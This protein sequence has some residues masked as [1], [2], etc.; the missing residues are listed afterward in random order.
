[1]Q[2]WWCKMI[3]GATLVVS[4]PW[5]YAGTMFNPENKHLTLRVQLRQILLE[6]K[7]YLPRWYGPNTS[8][9]NRYTRSIT[10]L[11]INILRALSN[12]R[13]MADNQLSSGIEAP[14]SYIISSLILSQSRRYMWN[15]VPRSTWLGIISRRHCRYLNF[16]VFVISFMVSMKMTFPPIMRQEDH[17]FK[18]KR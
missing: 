8:W 17:W 11:S 18:S 4:W 10:I 15:C 16:F 12:W 7:M 9:K 14:I 13:R 1:M 3:L 5:K 6:C 2:N